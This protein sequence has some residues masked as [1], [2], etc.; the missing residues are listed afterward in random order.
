MAI[1]FSCTIRS[2]ELESSKN[3]IS[4]IGLLITLSLAIMWG[5]WFFTVPIFSYEVSHEISVTSEE[6]SITRFP[7]ENVGALRPQTLQKRTILAKY[8]TTVIKNLQPSQTAFLRLDG[9]GKQRKAIPVVV[10]ETMD[11]PDPDKGI[12]KLHTMIEETPFYPFEGNEQGEIF[13]GRN[14]GVPA[15]FVLRASGLLTEAP[16]VISPTSLSP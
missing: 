15:H 9:P 7:Q 8:P 13:I 12:V 6:E 11:S 10:V 4:L 14:R 5:Y 3:Y 16:S 1:P 2:L